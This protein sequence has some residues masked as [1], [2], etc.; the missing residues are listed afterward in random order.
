MDD[1]KLPA[2]YL[3]RYSDAT[4][5][6]Q[7]A[8]LPKTLANPAVLVPSKSPEEERPKAAWYDWRQWSLRNPRSWSLRKQLVVASTVVVIIIVV[9]VGAYEGVKANRYPDY[10]PL[11][12]KLVDI[13]GGI[14]F[15]DQFDYFSGEDPTNGHV[16]YV[17]E[18]AALDLNLTHATDTSAILRVDS[19]TP[20]AVGG[21]NSAR[22]ES[23]KAYDQGLFIFDILHTPYGCGTWPALWL[24]DGYNWPNN[25]E[26]DILETTNEGS[27]GNAVTLHTTDGCKMD[28][29]RKQTGSALYKD[30]G[31]TTHSNAGCS[32]EGDPST[33][34]REFNQRGGGVYA[35]ELRAEGVPDISS[36]GSSPNPSNWGTA[37][38]DFPNTNCD[39]SSHF[40]NQSIIA[41][42]D[43]CGD[44]AAQPQYYEKMYNCP[45]T[46]PE[47]V[48][49][50]PSQF[51]DAYWE[52]RSFKVYQP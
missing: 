33:Y 28:V 46:C 16:V 9:V 44:L 4:S 2:Q 27:R 26:I 38:A 7:A 30:C 37:L 19:S 21:R 45:A 5:R 23:K 12:Y 32:V 11:D 25:G 15:F 10:R 8:D 13:Y 48:S 22:I 47:F 14:S 41:N 35:L 51:E 52:F 17:N 36:A 1:R 39:I 18:Q 20:N 50:N 24:V 6:L 34:G 3:D 40:R 49:N 42:I 29:K 31:N 43:L